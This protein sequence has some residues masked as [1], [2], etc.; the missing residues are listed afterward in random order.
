MFMKFLQTQVTVP[1]SQ[2]P[3]I[4]SKCTPDPEVFTGEES[5]IEQIY[6][7]FKTF[8]ISLNLKMTLNLDHMPMLEACIAYTFS[9]TSEKA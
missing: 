8:R 4:K 2:A 6:E 1:V 9:R 7:R 3:S 5:F